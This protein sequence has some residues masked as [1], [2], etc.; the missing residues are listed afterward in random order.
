[1]LVELSRAQDVQ[2]GDG[3]TSV[4]V[5]AG[6]LLDAAEKL[7]Q[8][9]IH[10]TA[11]SDSFQRCASK[12]SA[13]LTEM[14]YPIELTDRESLVKSASTSLN[15]KVVSQ[16]SSLLAPLAVDAVMK[17]SDEDAKVP[18][19]DLKNIKIIQSLGGTIEDTELVEGLVF[20][21]RASGSNGPK[22]LEKAKIGLIQFCISPPKTDVSSNLRLFST[23]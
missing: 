14:S 15:S 1:M 16:Y 7:L 13:I 6:A 3:T 2:A 10:P 17:V 8:M 23:Y 18:S 4:V 22:R 19:V 21:Q 12:A 9:G 11:I 5:I 20:T